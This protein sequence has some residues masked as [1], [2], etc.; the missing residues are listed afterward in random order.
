MPARVQLTV[1]LDFGRVTTRFDLHRAHLTDGDVRP[2]EGMP[3]TTPAKSIVDAAVAGTGPEQIEQAVGQAIAR[4]LASPD[5][6]LSVAT[7]PH[8]RHRRTVLPLI[9]SAI[10]RAAA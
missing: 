3:V 1:P 7:R 5:Q 8:Y 9:E 6:L 10:R 2:Y 4:A